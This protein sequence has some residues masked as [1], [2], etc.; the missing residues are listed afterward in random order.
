[1]ICRFIRRRIKN[2]TFNDCYTIMMIIFD[3]NHQYHD[4][5]EYDFENDEGD[6]Y[7]V[8]HDDNKFHD[9]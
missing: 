9:D 4:H 2:N 6:N 7:D 3:D 1:M 5:D 8:N